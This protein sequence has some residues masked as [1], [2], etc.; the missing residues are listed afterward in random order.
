L[1]V[2]VRAGRHVILI[3]HDC[4][5]EVP[6]PSGPNWLRFEPRLQAPGSGKN[7]IRLRVREWADHVLFYGYDNTPVK[8]GKMTD[9]GRQTRTVYP[10]EMPHCMAKSRVADTAVP[11]VKNDL[12]FWE[13]IIR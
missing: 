12:T 1:D 4:T 11:V 6:N 8:D 5:T 3:A 13:K 2:H 7:S 10:I 9:G